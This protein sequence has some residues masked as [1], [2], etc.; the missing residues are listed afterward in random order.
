[1]RNGRPRYDAATH[2]VGNLQWS[3]LE[4]LKRSME[5]FREALNRDL[6]V[7]IDA[8][9]RA[10]DAARRRQTEGSAALGFGSRSIPV[11]GG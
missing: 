3:M 7:A 4:N 8:T 9:C 10:L 5:V 1:M 11:S 6:R 2:N